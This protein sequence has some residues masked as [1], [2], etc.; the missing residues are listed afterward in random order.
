MVDGSKGGFGGAQGQKP[1][2]NKDE[3]AKPGKDD[4][5]VVTDSKAKTVSFTKAFEMFIEQ[6]E[7]DRVAM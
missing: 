6:K 1:A 3:K 2:G 4:S 5:K 7:R